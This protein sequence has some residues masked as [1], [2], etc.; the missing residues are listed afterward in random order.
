MFDRNGTEY[1]QLATT[2]GGSRIRGVEYGEFD[3]IAWIT[4]KKDRPLIAN[5]MLDGILPSDLKVPDSE[6]KGV[7]VKKVA[8]HPVEGKLTLD[9]KPFA[10]ANVTFYRFNKDTEKYNASATAAPTRRAVSQMSTYN[11]LRRRTGRRVHGHGRE[12]RGGGRG[13]RP[14]RRTSCPQS[15]ARPRSRRSR[16]RSRPGR[17]TWNW[18]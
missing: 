11:G 6:E 3:H 16:S 17:T 9:G 15:T 5:V 10:G 2:G 1:Y 14:G 4:M 18:T 8:T 13:R 12:G 7:V